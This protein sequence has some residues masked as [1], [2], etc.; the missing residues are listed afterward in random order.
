[1]QVASSQVSRLTC[2]ED[3]F[4]VAVEV[5]ERRNPWVVKTFLRPDS[6][7]SAW[8]PLLSARLLP[9]VPGMW[10]PAPLPLRSVRRYF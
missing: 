2:A 4:I 7:W 10:P 9:A 1:M 8:E 6:S 5:P 3:Y